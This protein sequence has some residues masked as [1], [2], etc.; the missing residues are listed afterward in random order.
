V[1]WLPQG[2]SGSAC[3]ITLAKSGTVSCTATGTNIAFVTSTTTN[4]DV[5]GVAGAQAMCSAAAAG[6]GLPGHYAPWLATS[7]VS[8]TT[9]LG[10]ARGWVRPDGLPFTDTLAGL[11]KGQVFYPLSINELGQS[12]ADN[13]L[14]W[15][16]A[17]PTGAAPA[18]TCSDWTRTTPSDSGA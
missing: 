6:A 11:A 2:C 18:V 13:T 17:S 12:V 1:G 7:T 3:A 9:A 16:G 4:G 10:A 8:A 5:G 14:V 15:T